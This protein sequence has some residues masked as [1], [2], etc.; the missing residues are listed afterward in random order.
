MCSIWLGSRSPAL[1]LDR[2]L[3]NI[4]FF[5]NCYKNGVY[6]LNLALNLWQALCVCG[7]VCMLFRPE[8]TH[9]SHRSVL[10]TDLNLLYWG[11]GECDVL[12]KEVCGKCFVLC[13]DEVPGDKD[14]WFIGNM[15][16]FYFYEM[17]DSTT[18][19]FVDPPSSARLPGSKGK[20]SHRYDGCGCGLLVWRLVT[21]KCCKRQTP[22]GGGV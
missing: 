5:I 8:D 18:R 14:D 13:G 1:R 16:R 15:D 2:K 10:E 19:T 4:E 11:G 20:V 7:C 12:A 21:R 22:R 6:E 3:C 17:Y 9:K